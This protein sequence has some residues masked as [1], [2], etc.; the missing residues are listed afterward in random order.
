M[1]E[2]SLSRRHFLGA[3]TGAAAW[4][5]IMPS[6]LLA[7]GEEAARDGALS[8]PPPWRVLTVEQAATIDAFAA[9]IIPADAGGPGAREAH[10]TRFIDNGLASF[11]KE[12]RPELEQALAALND[13]TVRQSTGG[14]T[15]AALN[16]VQQNAVMQALEKSSPK[17]FDALRT[18][19]IAGM[20][21][22]PSYG[23]NAGKA[24]WKLIGFE[25]RFFWQPPFGYYDRD[26]GGHG[27]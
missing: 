16:P 3:A 24:G 20:F 12:Q 6:V 15:F 9:Q 23:G 17:A 18:P 13:E 22:D 19:V 5:A 8:P 21:A 2:T 25:D 27:G 11:A 7:A 26:A 10:A 14:A 1:H 4:L